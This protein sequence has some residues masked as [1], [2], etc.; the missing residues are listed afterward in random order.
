MDTE[1]PLLSIAEDFIPSQP[2]K[3]AGQSEQA[4]GGLLDPPLVMHED[5]RDGCGG[6]LWPAGMVLA[7]YLLERP[8]LLRGKVMLVRS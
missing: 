7:R 1:H 3:L 2:H 8:E 6:Q 5:L 4:F